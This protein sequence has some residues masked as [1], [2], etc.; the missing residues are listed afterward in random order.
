MHFFPLQIILLI[1]AGGWRVFT[2]G[3]PPPSVNHS[4]SEPDSLNHAVGQ[5]PSVVVR[6]FVGVPG[7][8]STRA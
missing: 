2:V 7:E 6:V 1:T 4:P 5:V 3:H 8:K